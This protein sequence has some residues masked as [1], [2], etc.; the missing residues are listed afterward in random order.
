[1]ASHMIS[2]KEPDVAIVPIA[3]KMHPLYYKRL[4]L[5]MIV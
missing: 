1:M 4:I 3:G 5:I 2:A